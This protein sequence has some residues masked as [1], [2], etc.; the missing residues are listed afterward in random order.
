MTEIK[1]PLRVFLCHA[2]NDKLAV[3]A[4]YKRLSDDGV[5]AWLDKAK[6]VPGQDWQLEIQ[7]A[8]KNSDVV[9]VCLSAQSITK[10]GFVQK[11]IRV[12]LDTA[13][14]KPDGTIFIIPARLEACDVPE[15]MSKFQWVD[16]FSDNGYEQLIKAL[17]LRADKVGATLDFVAKPATDKKNTN[18]FDLSSDSDN[19]ERFHK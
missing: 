8:V 6:L 2:S 13:D 11:E 1:R 19:L 14:E 18:T 3:Q 4:L 10:E 5:D 7:R 15:R 9:I 16:L 17:K 12:A